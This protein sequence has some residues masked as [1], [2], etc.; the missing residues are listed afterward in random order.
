MNLYQRI[1]TG[2]ATV[3]IGVCLT[4]CEGKI[5]DS[6]GTVTGERPYVASVKSFSESV[7]VATGDMDGDGKT[8]IVLI[9]RIANQGEVYVLLNKGNGL[10]EFQTPKIEQPKNKEN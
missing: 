10:Y 1:I 5:K 6:K 2:I 7:S 9:S 4:G 8:D 3:G